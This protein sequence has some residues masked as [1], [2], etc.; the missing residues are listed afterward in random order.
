[1]K[2]FRYL[3]GCLVERKMFNQIFTIQYTESE[4]EEL[5]GYLRNEPNKVLYIKWL[6][7]LGE[8]NLAYQ[9]YEILLEGQHASR[10]I[11]ID[12]L[13][14][15]KVSN[16]PKYTKI[17][18]IGQYPKVFE[19]LKILADGVL[20]GHKDQ[21]QTAMEE[22]GE[23]PMDTLKVVAKFISSPFFL[24]EDVEIERNEKDAV[25]LFGYERDSEES[26][27]DAERVDAGNHSNRMDEELDPKI[28]TAKRS[29]KVTRN[30]Y[31]RSCTHWVDE[32]LSL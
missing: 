5:K 29:K 23:M 2:V 7:A 22:E 15:I 11:H 28:V 27:A 32:S 20:E 21:R 9:E 8:M 30:Y 10:V 26:E 1:M 17:F 6:I 13:I 18:L 25:D 14:K 19:E 4:R 16:A 24:N 3:V 12:L 31:L